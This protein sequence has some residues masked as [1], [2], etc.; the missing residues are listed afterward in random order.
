M[1]YFYCQS[2]QAF[3]LALAMNLDEEVTVITSVQNIVKACKFLKVKCVEHKLF[4]TNRMIRNKK[5]VDD[6][7]NYLIKI[8]Q[9]DELHFS[10][11]Q[12]AIFCFYLV[13]KINDKKGKTIFHN[14]EFVYSQISLKSIFNKNYIFKKLKQLYIKNKCNLPIEVRT[15]TNNSYMLSFP[16]SYINRSC[17]EIIDDKGTYYETT[18]KMFK[19][20]EFNYPEIENL[21]IAQTFTNEDLFKEDRINQLFPVINS[22]RISIKHHPKLGKVKGLEK[23]KVLP[24]FLPVELFFQKVTKNIFSFHSASLITASKFDNVTTLSLLNIVRTDDS[25]LDEMKKDM[26]SKSDGKILFIDSV[27]KLKEVLYV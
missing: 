25:F 11:T 7:I 26:I 14:F 10:H 8:I 22:K 15:S 23:C 2:Y 6:E 19:N 21:F 1:K 12:F 4:G 5:D 3:N 27:N 20:I 16:L 24:D 9:D 13:K 18:L 17:S